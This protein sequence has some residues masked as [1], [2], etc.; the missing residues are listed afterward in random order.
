MLVWGRLL[1]LVV[2]CLQLALSIREESITWDED[3]HIYAG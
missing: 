3:D 1:R 2:L